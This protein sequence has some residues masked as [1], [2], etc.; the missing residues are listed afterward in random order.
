[1]VC[2]PVAFETG[3]RRP[4][5]ISN[6]GLLCQTRKTPILTLPDALALP[7]ALT[8][9]K[10]LRLSQALTLSKALT[11]PK[12]PTLPKALTLPKAMTLSQ[13]ADNTHKTKLRHARKITLFSLPGLACH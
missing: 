6:I 4:R 8:L 9:P 11:L 5:S 1:M 12:A 3:T 2:P 7:K 13:G 10:A